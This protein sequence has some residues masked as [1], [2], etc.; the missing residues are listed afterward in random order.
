MD[1]NIFEEHA[2][3]IFM[4]EIGGAWMHSNYKYKL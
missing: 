3:Y 1:T 4:V 2:A